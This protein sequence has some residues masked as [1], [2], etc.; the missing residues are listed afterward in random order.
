[1]KSEDQKDENSMTPTVEIY[2]P[3]KGNI[4][5]AAQSRGSRGN[6]SKLSSEQIAVL[7]ATLTNLMTGFHPPDV[8]DTDSG[9]KLDS[10]E[11]ELAFKVET[12]T[13]TAI[14]L[15]LDGKVEASITAK[16]GWKK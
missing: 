15:L 4:T 6:D 12:G 11:L 5:S 13:G 10:L 2:I 14:K 1:M 7:Q 8:S 16:V 9:L 3:T